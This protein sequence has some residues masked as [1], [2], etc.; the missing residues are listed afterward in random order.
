MFDLLLRC[1][2]DPYQTIIDMDLADTLPELEELGMP[3]SEITIAEKLKE[4]GYH[5]VHIGKWHLGGTNG[6]RPEDQG[7][8]ES[9]YMSG[10]LYL[11]EDSPE[12][13]NAKLDFSEID[14]MVWASAWYSAQFNGG[15]EFKP[16]GYLTDYYT[17]E[18]INVIEAN[19]NRPF[20]LYLAHWGIHNPL[21][22]K[23]EDYD[24]LSHINDHRLRVYA[25]MIRSLDRSV[26]RVMAA[27]EANGLD[28]NT[29]VIF[30]SDNGGA[31]YV[32]L[33]D[34][35]QPY[36]GWKTTFFEGGI[37]VP[38]FIRWPQEI[39]AGTT[40]DNP[41]THFDIF[42]TAAAAAGVD[43]P[44]DRTMD[45]VD[46]VPYIKGDEVTAPHETL[47]WRTGH[48]QVVLSSGWKMS[49]SDRPDKVWLYNLT[50][51]PTE[52]TNLADSNPAKVAELQLLLDVHNA[53][54]M[55]PIWPS[56]LEDPVTI[57]KT[58]EDQM[59]ETDEY[60]YWVN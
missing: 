31:P 13:V 19:R 26:E 5:T 49:V 53:Q 41:V 44:G 51:D 50:V 54:Q 55:E 33:P 38:Y 18:A 47:F 27:L 9:L 24:A 14:H 1:N 7:F 23:K 48:Y 21:Q 35:N 52:Q 43:L 10:I 15:P 4:A 36:R 6:S 17:D 46:L 56:V 2:T 42:A 34:I 40:Y 57:D 8:D 37:H 58:D 39:S 60:I 59:L 12:V 29:L 25:A 3:P 30:T 22:A 32:G 28:E 16:N 45:G 20:F 11:P